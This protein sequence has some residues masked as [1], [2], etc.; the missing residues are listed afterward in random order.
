ML[1]LSLVFISGVICGVVGAIAFGSY[2]VKKLEARQKVRLADAAKPAST[3]ARKDVKAQKEAYAR[4]KPRLDRAAQI[5]QEQADIMNQAEQPSKNS[6]H[7]RYKNGLI[8]QAKL[9]E[10][11]KTELLRSIIADGFDPEITVQTANGI[12]KMHLSEY[13]ASQG[14]DLG[15]KPATNNE[16]PPASTEEKKAEPS[17]RKVGKFFVIKGGK[18]ET[19]H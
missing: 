8:A 13:L 14:Y 2:L 1:E 3:D 5:T 15:S 19:N 16:A 12:E 4:V 9:L 17:I 7:S 6:L 10:E 11:E 18:D